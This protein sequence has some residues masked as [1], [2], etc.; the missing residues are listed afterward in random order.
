[1]SEMQDVLEAIQESNRWLRV[2]AAPVLRESFGAQFIGKN[3][4]YIYQNSTGASSRDVGQAAKRVE[5]LGSGRS[6]GGY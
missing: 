3:D 6:C 2:L 1:M 4:W 5:T